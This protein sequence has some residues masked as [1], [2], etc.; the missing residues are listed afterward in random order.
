MKKMALVI[1]FSIIAVIIIV[2]LIGKINL[3]RQF[4]KEVKKLFAQSK[5]QSSR[6]FSYESINDLPA[7]VQRYFKHVLNE[8]QPN[9][10]SLII[11][12]RVL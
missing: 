12:S 5:D 3:S 2:F 9:I 6:K 8:G 1:T 10:L 7:P 11:W 4:E